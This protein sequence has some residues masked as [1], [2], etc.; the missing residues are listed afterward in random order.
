MKVVKVV[1]SVLIFLVLLGAAALFLIGRSSPKPGG[2]RIETTPKSSIFI[3]GMLVGETPFQGSYKAGTITLKLIPKGTD[4][5]LIPFET[6]LMLASGIETVIGRN[7]D[8]S[9]EESS[10]YV[11]TFEKS[12]NT[13]GLIAFSQPTN[14]Q[15]LI[16]G[17][18]RGFSPYE[19]SAIAPAN[20]TITVKSPGYL[21]FSMTV[22]TLT[23]YRLNFY[24][25]LA[26]DAGDSES[27]SENET[28]KVVT[29]L[30]TPTGY[31]RVRSEPGSGGEEMAQ[32][33]PGE[34]FPYLDTDVATGWIEIQYE[35]PK[36]GL[37]AGITGWVSGE[38]ATV[39][40][41]KK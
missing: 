25:K 20:H 7:F 30:N 19:T 11:I 4:E 24:A 36:S 5:K 29:I 22:K 21:D 37:P 6:T 3:N 9:E 31:L 41:E 1:L 14:A 28:R 32:V 10:G 17:V 35:A 15:V 34:S 39:S 2:L 27:D 12:K 18:S 33:R 13:A 23:G 8:T 38:Y 26:K 40:A 16:D